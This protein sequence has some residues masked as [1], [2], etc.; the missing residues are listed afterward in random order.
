[1]SY[2]GIAI[3]SYDANAD[4]LFVR[5]G[6]QKLNLQ[7]ELKTATIV[8]KS[9][10]G[11]APDYPKSMFTDQ[12]AI[13]TYSLRNSEVKLTVPLPRTNFQLPFLYTIT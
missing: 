9:L 1:M 6:W 13:S 10:N 7:R 3:S 5:L 11:L 2:G 12:S 4:D 8:Y